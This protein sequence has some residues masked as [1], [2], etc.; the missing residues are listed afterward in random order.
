MSLISIVLTSIGLGMDAFAVSICKGLSIKNYSIYKSIIVGLYFGLFQGIMPLIGYVLGSGFTNIISDFDHYIIFI[1]L[2]GIGFNMIRDGLSNDVINLND[3]VTFKEMFPL[4]VATSVDA[5]AVGITCAFL[6]INIIKMILII[7]TITF[8]MTFIGVK[9]G[10]A[11][12]IKY[13][14][15]AQI[16]GGLILIILSFKI[17]IEHLFF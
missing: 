2:F 15:K 12:G 14:K 10:N 6:K 11:V 3:L 8:I 7:S 4:A 13:E 17:L 5:L 16:I 1:L 9:I